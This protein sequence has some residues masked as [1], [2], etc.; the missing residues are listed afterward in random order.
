MDFLFSLGAVHIP[1][2]NA[3]Q[4]RFQFL[5]G[6]PGQLRHKGHI[7]PRF[8][9]NGHREGFAGGVHRGHGNMG[10]DGAFGEHI[11]LALE[12]A[13]LIQHLQRTQEKVAG[14]LPKG[15]TVAPAGQQTVLF[16]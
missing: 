10:T 16:R 11:R 12:I 6:F 14:I 5:L 15:Q 13:L 2:D 8:F 4:L 9:R 7:H 1:E 3:C